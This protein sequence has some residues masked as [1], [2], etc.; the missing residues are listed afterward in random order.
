MNCKQFL[1]I[2]QHD[3][4]IRVGDNLPVKENDDYNVN[5]HMGLAFVVCDKQ[6]LFNMY[7]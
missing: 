1:L 6:L 7:Q 2:G 4:L 5:S 3:R